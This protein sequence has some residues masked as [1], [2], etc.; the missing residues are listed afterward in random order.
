MS[1][2]LVPKL[3]FAEYP[4]GDLSEEIVVRLG[5]RLG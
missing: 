3:R 2:P 4:V 1:T 5:K